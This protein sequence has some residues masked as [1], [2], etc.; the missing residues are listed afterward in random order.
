M[1]TNLRFTGL[2]LLAALL[3]LAILAGCGGTGSSSSGGGG[4]ATLTF[5][6]TV[7]DINGDPVPGA[8]VQMASRMLRLPWAESGSR[9][10]FSGTT[11][12]NGNFTFTGLT[13][14]N[15][16]LSVLQSE[17]LVYAQYDSGGQVAASVTGAAI[18]VISDEDQWDEVVNNDDEHPF[19]PQHGYIQVNAGSATGE[20]LSQVT[21]NTSNGAGYDALGYYM[22]TPRD[23][24]EVMN[25]S[26][27][28]TTDLGSGMLYGVDP[29]PQI[30]EAHQQSYSFPSQTVDVAA[31]HI[32]LVFMEGTS[33]NTYTVGGTL[34]ET[35][36][37]TPI[38]GAE[39]VL[40]SRSRG[41]FKGKTQRYTTHT[42][43]DGSYAF[44]HVAEGDYNIRY[45]KDTYVS[46]NIQTTVTDDAE[47]NPSLVQE[48]QWDTFMGDANHPYDEDSGYIMVQARRADNMATIPGVVIAGSQAYTAR[49]YAQDTVPV[50]ISYSATS[51]ANNGLAFFYQ[52]NA[53]SYTF[54]A[55]KTGYTFP[56]IFGIVP[57]PGEI[58]FPLILATGYPTGNTISGTIEQ[59]DGTA[60]SGATVTL[61][62]SGRFADTNAQ[63]VFTITNIDSNLYLMRISKNTDYLPL[64]TR[65]TIAQDLTGLK[66]PLVQTAAFD[67]FHL[68]GGAQMMM[69]KTVKA[70]NQEGLPGCVSN[71]T[72]PV[73]YNDLG[74]FPGSND[75]I[76]F[77]QSNRTHSNGYAL[78]YGLSNTG[79]EVSY[80][81]AKNGYTFDNGEIDADDLVDGEVY[82]VRNQGYGPDTFTVNGIVKDMAGD[83]AS[84][85]KVELLSDP[86]ISTITEADGT[87][88][89]TEVPYG[90][91]L[92]RVNH[93]YANTSYAR[94]NTYYTVTEDVEYDPN[95]N[96]HNLQL[97]CFTIVELNAMLNGQTYHPTSTT[98]SYLGIMGELPDGNGN[99]P[100]TS[101]AAS[102]IW[103]A[104]GYLQDSPAVVNWD[105]TYAYTN[106]PVKIFYEGA[107][108]AG[109]SSYLLTPTSTANNPGWI[110]SPETVLAFPGELTIKEVKAINY[111]TRTFSGDIFRYWSTG[112]PGVN[113]RARRNYE[114]DHASLYVTTTDASGDFLFDNSLPA[115]PNQDFTLELP[116]GYLPSRIRTGLFND[117]VNVSLFGF[118]GAADFDAWAN[119]PGSGHPYSDAL[120]YYAVYYLNGNGQGITQ[121]TADFD[122]N[123]P[124]LGY[125]N[126]SGV[127]DWSATSTI[128]NG[129]ALGYGFTPNNSVQVTG[130]HATSLFG[131]L[132]AWGDDGEIVQVLMQELTHP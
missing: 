89:L 33:T 93:D 79:S 30:V 21:F 34:T 10:A 85:V 41:F 17:G 125:H 6:G 120:T 39:A 59:V 63:G 60:V 28:Q 130:A 88:T 91:Q 128:S 112:I 106:Q 56:A 83:G 109:G 119:T 94:C 51:T 126:G 5:A 107:A 9:A 24:D 66:F 68:P 113:I 114:S 19:D 81:S 29:D 78:F 53:A 118:N 37:S 84:D 36:N 127:I 2:F 35:D 73:N 80:T 16:N 105:A 7:V 74:I 110:F 69:V 26:L 32:H 44:N 40:T 15:Y 3:S 45:S 58:V 104:E 122:P 49:G 82:F 117:V 111:P 54:T 20:S 27:T 131:E 23:A 121:V 62:G 132:W 67:G 18:Q 72:A 102:G 22:E 52:T 50:T 48:A 57:V 38:A 61:V 14:G 129:L 100:K 47:I 103:T 86:S 65:I 76:D 99:I 95:N 70:D 43:G 77:L 101:I 97:M 115:G 116:E 123:A 12:E 11:D 75:C 98:M 46:L 42:N 1:N 92:L 87:F 108:I 55:T 96:E 8:G 4:G 71:I 25:W 124:S 90:T 64:R 31:G 13:A